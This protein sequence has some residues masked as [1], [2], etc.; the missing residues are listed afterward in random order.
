M[1]YRSDVALALKTADFNMLLKKSKEQRPDVYDLIQEAKIFANEDF[2]TIYWEWVKWYDFEPDIAYIEEFKAHTEHQ[3]HKIGENYEDYEYTSKGE[4][5]HSCIQFV[6]R[7]D[8]LGKEVN[9][10]EVLA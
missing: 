2:I 7:L 5:I 4:S 9:L 6:R 1:G 3:F 8:I 10:K